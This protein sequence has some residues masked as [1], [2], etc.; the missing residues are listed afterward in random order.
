MLYE[1]W[2]EVARSCR[3]QIALRDL[4]SGR[5]WTFHDLALAT[6]HAERAKAGFA[7][8]RGM[9]AEFVLAVLQAWRAE[10]IVCPLELDQ[11]QPEIGPGLPKG[12]VHLKTTSATTGRPRLV[13][14]TA[15]QLMADAENIVGTMGLRPDWPN[16]GVV[17]LAHS[18]GFSNLILPLLLHGIPLI[19]AGAPLPEVIRRA[20]AMERAVTL[21][22]VPALWRSWHDANAIPA[23]VRLAISAGAPLPLTLEENVFAMR[24]LKIHNFYG[25]SECG[26]I[27]YDAG[28]VPRTDG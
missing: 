18:Y 6:E 10:R 1:H 14:F 4:D 13:A 21:A 20:A 17:S 22:G 3:D 27:A 7:F 23:N 5:Q 12:I 26:G 16:V 24:G 28:A 15:A 9:S 25:S 2:R 19:I 8:P 11:E